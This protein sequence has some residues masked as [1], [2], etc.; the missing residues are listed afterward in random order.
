MAATTL[1]FPMQVPTDVFK[2]CFALVIYETWKLMNLPDFQ[3]I[4]SEH[5]FKALMKILFS[6]L[7]KLILLLW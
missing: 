7:E 4:I 3:N 2:D 6:F 5:L 1:I